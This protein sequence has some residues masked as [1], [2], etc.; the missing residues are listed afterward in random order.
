ML[1]Y[2]SKDGSKLGAHFSF[3]YQLIQNLNSSSSAR[4]YVD[5]IN[6]WMDYMPLQHTENWIVGTNK[7]TKPLKLVNPS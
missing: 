6:T 2:G 3:N 4:N 7:Q 1:Y 5:A